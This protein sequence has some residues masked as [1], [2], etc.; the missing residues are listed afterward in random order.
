VGTKLKV[1]AVLGICLLGMVNV[2][3][4]P[5]TRADIW[6]LPLPVA[7]LSRNCGEAG[8]TAGTSRA[9]IAVVP[10]GSVLV[11]ESHAYL[12]VGI[13]EGPSWEDVRGILD[14]QAGNAAQYFPGGRSYYLIISNGRWNI[15]PDSRW[16]CFTTAT[17]PACSQL[18]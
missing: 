18:D 13:A 10:E 9:C 5:T 14:A 8:Q 4:A 17:M 7:K 11:V 16:D 3:H 6:E 1:L 2:G 12:E 15:L